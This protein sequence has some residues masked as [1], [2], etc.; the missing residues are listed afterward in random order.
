MWQ[1]LIVI[2]AVSVAALYVFWSLAPKS[3]RRWAATR[4]GGRM[5]WLARSA[6]SSGCADC[7]AR[8]NTRSSR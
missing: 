1:N 7:A 5:T 8:N 6:D 4:W 2:V 3:V